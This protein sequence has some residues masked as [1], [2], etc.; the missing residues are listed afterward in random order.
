MKNTLALAGV[1][2]G[3]LVA[4]AA[5]TSLTSV[6]TATG[7][8]GAHGAGTGSYSTT[9]TSLTLGATVSSSSISITSATLTNPSGTVI[10]TDSAPTATA[11]SSYFFAF[12]SVPTGVALTTANVANFVLKFYHG[13][14]LEASGPLSTTPLTTTPEPSSIAIV[15]GAALVGFAAFRR[16]RR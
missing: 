14:T 4:S 1:I 8:S 11:G 6:I 7:G 2:L 12:S 5:T 3:T 9:L 15:A 13:S 10:H 16:A